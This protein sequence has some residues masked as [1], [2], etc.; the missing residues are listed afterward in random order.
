[1]SDVSACKPEPHAGEHTPS[2]GIGG[3]HAQNTSYASGK[4]VEFGCKADSSIHRS[5]G[6][7]T[8]VGTGRRAKNPNRNTLAWQNMDRG[9]LARSSWMV[10]RETSSR[11]SLRR[12]HSHVRGHDCAGWRSC[13][14]MGRL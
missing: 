2:F 5:C 1:M 8:G 12:L 10:E 3:L 13:F 9:K 4:L 14:S 11:K 6:A 7:G